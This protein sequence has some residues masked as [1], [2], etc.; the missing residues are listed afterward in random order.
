MMKIK[1]GMTD[2]FVVIQTS[3]RAVI[4]VGSMSAS[5][6]YS[7]CCVIQQLTSVL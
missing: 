6:I 3:R 2:R 1:S 4:S 7:H 5:E